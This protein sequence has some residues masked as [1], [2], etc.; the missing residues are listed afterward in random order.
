MT[1]L[2]IY[3]NLWLNDNI[4]LIYYIVC[5]WFILFIDKLVIKNIQLILH[6]LIFLTHAYIA[7]E[8]KFYDYNLLTQLVIDNWILTFIFF[9][10]IFM[11]G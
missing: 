6:N 11:H 1:I 2:I 3:D 8:T 9:S 4:E 5:G 7:Y 10:L